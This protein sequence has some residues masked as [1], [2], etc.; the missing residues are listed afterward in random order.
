MEYSDLLREAIRD[1][2]GT[3]VTKFTWRIVLQK[4]RPSRG[5][6]YD[7][8]N[9]AT[10]WDFAA[11]VPGTRTY[12]DGLSNLAQADANTLMRQK[13]PGEGYRLISLL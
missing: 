10:S 3:D 1:G 6:L 4:R 12:S 13:P 9:E 11:E 2:R 8:F 5:F 7:L